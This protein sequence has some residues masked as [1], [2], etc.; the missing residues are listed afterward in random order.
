M[1]KTATYLKKCE[2]NPKVAPPKHGDLVPLAKEIKLKFHE[3]TEYLVDY[4]PRG[5]RR[6]LKNLRRRAKIDAGLWVPKS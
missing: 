1:S 5:N 2:A 3:K 4:S 6:H